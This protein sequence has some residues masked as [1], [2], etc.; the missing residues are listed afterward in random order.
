MGPPEL[1]RPLSGPPIASR[2]RDLGRT[3]LSGATKRKKKKAEEEAQKRQQGALDK[4]FAPQSE[5]ADSALTGTNREIAADAQI[6]EVA[7][8]SSS[9]VADISDPGNWPTTLNDRQRC[10]II[11][12]GPVRQGDLNYPRNKEGRCFT[13]RY[14]NRF[15]CN[16]ENTDR[17][18]LVYSIN[19]D[20]VY[21][22]CCKL[23]SDKVM[24][25]SKL[26]R[27][28]LPDWKHLGDKLS[29]HEKSGNHLKHFVQWKEHKLRL[30][31]SK[32]ID[33]DAQKELNDLKKYWRNVLERLFAI[34]HYLA[35]RN[36]SFRGTREKLFGA[37]RTIGPI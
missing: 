2:E 27:D 10:D 34:T 17:E 31:V 5:Q 37:R 22:F 25:T 33:E 11:E 8:E 29:D 30:S 20:A 15:I 4:Y 24:T 3:Y 14:Y 9:V 28:G 26:N 23:F 7:P 35:S 19:K 13:E 18:W 12:K 21:C 36:L 1:L 16:G 32:T 6:S